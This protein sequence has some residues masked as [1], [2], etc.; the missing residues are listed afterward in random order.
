MTTAVVLGRE[1][2]I[3]S[4]LPGGAGES[5]QQCGNSEDRNGSLSRARNTEAE[6]DRV[7]AGGDAAPAR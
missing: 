3:G 6:V 5:D 1:N 4:A 7:A 2:G